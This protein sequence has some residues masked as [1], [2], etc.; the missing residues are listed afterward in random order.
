MYPLGGARENKC[1]NGLPYGGVSMRAAEAQVGEGVLPGP[2]VVAV[3]HQHIWGIMIRFPLPRVKCSCRSRLSAT[4]ASR[5]NADA[6]EDSESLAACS[7]R[8]PKGPS[9][10][11]GMPRIPIRCRFA[12][13][14]KVYVKK[15]SSHYRQLGSEQRTLK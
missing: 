13:C 6:Q 10:S 7:H 11:M 15:E 8:P 2:P 9:S 5:P 3:S 1:A 12:V 4:H 14:L